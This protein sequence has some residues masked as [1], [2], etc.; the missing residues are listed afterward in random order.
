MDFSLY[1]AMAPSGALPRDVG[2][3]RFFC[4]FDEAVQESLP[5][6][7][8]PIFTDSAPY[9]GQAP[10]EIASRWLPLLQGAPGIVLDF[11][12][13]RQP[14]LWAFV[15]GLRPLL[16]CPI[17]PVPEY[18]DSEGPVFLPPIPP[19]TPLEEALAP[20]QGRE[21]W[22]DLGICT[23]KLTLTPMGCRS[24]EWIS[25]EAAGFSDDRLC[26][27]YRIEHPE[28]DTFRF[29]LWRSGPDIA[30][31]MEQGRHL[32]VR[33]YVGLYPEL[34]RWGFPTGPLPPDS[35]R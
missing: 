35:D 16:P 8:L 20:W 3:A 13:P 14:G 34:I 24:E 28:A 18:A 27:H 10:E 7:C 6:G 25:E 32:G 9:R 29:L 11:Q 4:P 22:L 30:S 12:R 1:L 23:R 26:C 31:L 2:Y 21:I 19:D 17:A 15:Q 5:E 33:R